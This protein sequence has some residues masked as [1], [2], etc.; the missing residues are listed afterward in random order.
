MFKKLLIAASLAGACVV[1]AQVAEAKVNVIIGI[2]Q[3]GGYCYYNYDPFRC[4]NYGH[5]P[6]PGYFVPHYVDRGRV[7]CDQA[8]WKLRNLGYRKIYATDCSGRSY[9]FIARKGSGKYRIEFNS[10]RNRITNVDRIG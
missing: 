2:G 4:R 7:S 10:L 1:S 8:I 5:Y 6:R 9:S 3:P